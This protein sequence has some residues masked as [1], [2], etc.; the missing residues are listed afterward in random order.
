MLI[1]AWELIIISLLCRLE[2]IVLTHFLDVH[3]FILLHA[4]GTNGV[5]ITEHQILIISGRVLKQCYLHNNMGADSKQQCIIV[6][7]CFDHY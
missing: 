6:L 3:S 2:K 5:N 4:N 7:L 1:L